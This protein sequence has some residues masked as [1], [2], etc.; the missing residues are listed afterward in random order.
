MRFR[1]KLFPIV[2]CVLGT[3][4]EY[5]VLPHRSLCQEILWAWS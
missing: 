2:V 4:F 3:T 5:L 1:V